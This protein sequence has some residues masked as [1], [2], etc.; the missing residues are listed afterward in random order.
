MSTGSIWMAFRI[1]TRGGALIGVGG[2]LA[3]DQILQWRAGRR[4]QFPATLRK[5]TRYLNPGVPDAERQFAWRGTSL[6]GSV[7]S[8]RL[9]EIVAR[10]GPLAEALASIRAEVRQAI[11]T[12][13]AA[14]ASGPRRL[15][16]RF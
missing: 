5:P 9:V 6:V 1:S 8:D 10:G 15:R 13:S 4:V 3:S 7:K 12:A 2:E 14:G 16:P 11:A